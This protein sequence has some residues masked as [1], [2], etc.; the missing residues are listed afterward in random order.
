MPRPLGP[1]PTSYAAISNETSRSRRS[2]FARNRAAAPVE[3][4]VGPFL[5]G[6][7]RYPAT[8]AEVQ[9]PVA[10]KKAT[11]RGCDRFRGFEPRRH[12][13]RRRAS[14]G[15][16]SELGRHASGPAG[17]VGRASD[18]Q[19]RLRGAQLRVAGPNASLANARS[20]IAGSDSAG[21]AAPIGG[22]RG[23]R[24]TYWRT[25]RE[26]PHLLAAQPGASPAS[27]SNPRP[28]AWQADPERAL[29]PLYPCISVT[30]ATSP[31]RRPSPVSSLFV[32][33][34]APNWHR[35]AVSRIG[36]RGDCAA[37]VG[38]GSRISR[39]SD[40]GARR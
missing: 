22:Q 19:A 10:P 16:Q 4:D 15:A 1:D 13:G 11:P 32:G 8:S 35:D 38:C 25:A 29:F 3:P 33:V 39:R 21:I 14:A 6:A 26:S 30:S 37:W 9:H 12:R 24:R 36:S 7:A 31:H 20:I 27:G 2:C 5:H 17:Q 18:G 34:L 28:S 23:N 40:G